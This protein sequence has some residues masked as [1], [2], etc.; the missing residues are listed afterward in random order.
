M[1]F[2]AP[3]PEICRILQQFL[4][5][6]ALA[7]SILSQFE[8]LHHHLSGVIQAARFARECRRRGL[9]VGAPMPR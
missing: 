4:F 1:S 3:V 6:M 2:L 7:L 8:R 9:I 5:W